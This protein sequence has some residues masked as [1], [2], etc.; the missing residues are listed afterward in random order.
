[1]NSYHSKWESYLQLIA[2]FVTLLIAAVFIDKA[3]ANCN[4][5]FAEAVCARLGIRRN[6]GKR[7]RVAGKAPSLAPGD[8]QK[9]G[10]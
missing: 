8:Q 10:F 6:S 5:R 3:K 9:L 1:M 2:L 4:E 7:G